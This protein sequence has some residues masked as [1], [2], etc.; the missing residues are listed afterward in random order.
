MSINNPL[1]VRDTEWSRLRKHVVKAS[2]VFDIC[3][4]MLGCAQESFCILTINARN[5]VI[6]RHLVSLGLVDQAIIHPREVFQYALLDS[7]SRI[8]IIH[9][10]PSGDPTPSAEDIQI[11]RQLIDAGKIIDIKV[12]DHVIIALQ[13]NPALNPWCS[14]REQGLVLFV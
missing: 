4:D 9:N 6:D 2:D 13:D 10:H 11:T 14:L 1:C 12:I 8:I 7:A 3:K 5:Y